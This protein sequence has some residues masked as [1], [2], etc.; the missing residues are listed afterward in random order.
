MM[1]FKCCKSTEC[2]EINR[3]H[4]P[5]NVVQWPARGNMA[6]TFVLHKM[7]VASG[8]AGSLLTLQDRIDSIELPP[9]FLL[10]DVTYRMFNVCF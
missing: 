8:L 1:C 2:E 5:K 3:I 9:S 4:L 10:H 7:Q 6:L